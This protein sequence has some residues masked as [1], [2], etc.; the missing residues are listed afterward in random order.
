MKNLIGIA[1]PQS[2]FCVEQEMR[3]LLGLEIRYVVMRLH[4][5]YADAKV[6]IRE[7]L[8]QLP[9]LMRQQFATLNVQSLWFACT[10]SSYLITEQERETI[11]NQFSK[12]FPKT[13]LLL[14]SDAIINYLHSNSYKKIA[15]L[16]PYPNWL[17]E[18]AIDYYESNGFVITAVEQINHL[19]EF[20]DTTSIYTLSNNDT[21]DGIESL[22][23]QQADCILITGTGL[24]SLELLAQYQNTK[25][26]I[27]SSNLVLAEIGIQQRR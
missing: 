27:I 10:A 20:S 14:A 11:L 26:P 2:N 8:L 19:K 6:R 24:P 9:K 13:T 25:I 3:K 7:Y 4:N 23:T 16:S 22:L 12:L 18:K 21:R 15:I 1:T 5:E 17:T